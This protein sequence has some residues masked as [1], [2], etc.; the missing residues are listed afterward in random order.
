ML[1]NGN[2]DFKTQM[3]TC[4]TA[5]LTADNQHKAGREDDDARDR[6]VAARREQQRLS[7]VRS[8]SFFRS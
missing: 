2:Y 3:V 8:L 1:Q 7:I 4:I 5:E 6:M